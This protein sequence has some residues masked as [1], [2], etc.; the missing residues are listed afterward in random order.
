MIVVFKGIWEAQSLFPKIVLGT[1]VCKGEEKVLVN[2]DRGAPGPTYMA[3]SR[4]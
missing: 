3:F 2:L 4:H 1:I